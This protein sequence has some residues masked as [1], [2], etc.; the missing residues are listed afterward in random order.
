MTHM[1]STLRSGLIVSLPLLCSLLTAGTLR[2]QS[3]EP[4]PALIANAGAYPLDVSDDGSVTVGDSV[5]SAL[6]QAAVRWK[7]GQIA[8]LG[9]IAGDRPGA[10]AFGVSGDGLVAAGYVT[11]FPSPSGAALEQATRWLLTP[12]GPQM[13]PLGYL[14]EVTQSR[15]YAAS[16]D[17]SVV[18]GRSHTGQRIEA[19]RWK[20]GVMSGL[21]FLNAGPV[22]AISEALDVSADGAVVVGQSHNGSNRYEAFRWEAGQM[23]ALGFHDGS[24]TG[25]ESIARSVSADGRVVVGGSK[26]ASNDSVRPFRWESGQMAALPLPT[27]CSFAEAFGV[28]GNGAVVV[29]RARCGTADHAFVWTASG[30]SR[31]LRDVLADDLQLDLTGWSLINAASVSSDGRVVVGVAVNAAN[32]SVGVAYRAVLRAGSAIVVNIGTGTYQ[33]LSVDEENEPASAAEDRC[34][35]DRS[36]DGDQCTLRAAL[37][38]ANARGGDRITFDIPGGG[39]P[40]IRVFGERLPE[41]FHPIQID[42]T[43][44]PGGWV[45]LVGPGQ[46]S[47]EIPG[48]EIANGGS[49][50]SVRGLVI[51]GFHDAGIY[52][53]VGANSCTIESNRIGTDVT[54][55]Q[56]RRNGYITDNSLFRSGGLWVDADD[57]RVLRNVIAGNM[58][59]SGVGTGGLEVLIRGNRNVLEGNRIGVGVDDRPIVPIAGNSYHLFEGV[60]VEG[61]ENRIGGAGEVGGSRPC[62]NAACNTIEGHDVEIV[63]E[64][65]GNGALRNVISGN[66]I[67]L[68]SS[69]VPGARLT[70]V[71]I[72]SPTAH[73]IRVAYNDISAYR[74]GMILRQPDAEVLG[75]TVEADF[76]EDPVGATLAR[77]SWGAIIL[78]D[79]A[80]VTLNTVRSRWSSLNVG[81]RATVTMNHL[82]GS[83]Q[84]L[85]HDADTQL[86]AR[87]NV[88]ACLNQAD[89]SM[90]YLGGYEQ[91]SD[92]SV[93]WERR[94]DWGDLDGY[95]NAPVIVAS[96][97]KSDGVH[98]RGY[99]R[100]NASAGSFAVESHE[101]GTGVISTTEIDASLG[102]TDFEILL[103]APGNEL[104]FTATMDGAFTS[105]GVYFGT[106]GEDQLAAVE[107]PQ[108]GPSATA[109][110]LGVTVTVPNEPRARS[111]RAGSAAQVF[112]TRYDV[113]PT[114]N[115]FADTTAPAAGGAA[116]HPDSIAP[117]TWMV[118]DL[119]LTRE[120][121]DPAE[122]V[123]VDVCLATNGLIARAALDAV[124]VMQ[125]G[126]RHGPAWQPLATT[127]EFRDGVRLLCAR[128]LDTLG[129]FGL[130]ATAAT[131][132]SIPGPCEASAGGLAEVDCL[133]RGALE[134]A[135]CTGQKL[136]KSLRQGQKKAL[137]L[138]AAAAKATKPNKRRAGLRRA[139]GA[140]TQTAKKAARAG[141]G[142]PLTTACADA[143]GQRFTS[144]QALTTD[145]INP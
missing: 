32:P 26:L 39:V 116:I 103:D 15:A 107:M 46:D 74:N 45:E 123:T 61:D 142:R 43:T 18:V 11:Y 109:S 81:P 135:D 127:R 111:A 138:L 105:E 6:R 97:R 8:G 126:G 79:D 40:E 37:E 17:G 99:I 70:E 23:V 137:K 88:H 144:A 71:G 145:E 49:G 118:R 129:E 112:I 5:N 24:A 67:G 96:Y 48:I 83:E 55:T 21:G 54:G 33:G 92:P 101:C 4:L 108:I 80:Q 89:T 25:W 131:L 63:I 7:D 12:T 98:V 106:V 134:A 16:R 77:D 50:S 100:G 27:G 58:F 2:A 91:N 90:I 29:G 47:Q 76:R 141:N 86:L 3:F 113:V 139:V 78:G 93:R 94:N 130:G 69:N 85:V 73:E 128:G 114:A 42:A 95:Q 44:Q 143:V 9:Y 125:R 22:G 38:L 20:D 140:L 57:T 60:R 121:I 136:P 115:V 133:V 68:R 75:N 1:F 72:T 102:R 35:V 56:A 31:D 13:Q 41:L 34:D 51:H 10:R 82:V 132:Q 84:I 62:V 28:S 110:G 124:V 120:S 87:D 53:G 14:A 117:R 65:E 59:D 36:R 30:G 19:F 122:A 64:A 66:V 52:V 119:G 104:T